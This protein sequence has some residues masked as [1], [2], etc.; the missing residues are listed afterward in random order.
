MNIE[1][2]KNQIRDQLS[3][4]YFWRAYMFVMYGLHYILGLAAVTLSVTVAAKP[5][6]I[7][8]ATVNTLSWL[9]A[10]VTSLVAFI[11]PERVGER[12]QRAYQ[13]LSVVVTKFLADP[14]FTVSDV[15][16]AYEAGE[17]VIHQKRATE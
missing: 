12:Y 6:G 9:L 15:T 5:F 14:T 2:R 7:D 16:T 3:A 17:A 1:E 11:T 4:L 10:L 8:G 13:I